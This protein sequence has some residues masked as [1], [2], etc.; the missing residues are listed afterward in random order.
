MNAWNYTS[1]PPYV[2]MVYDLI[3]HKDNFT[4]TFVTLVPLVIPFTSHAVM[5]H[6]ETTS[7][8]LISSKIKSVTVK[9]VHI[10]SISYFTWLYVK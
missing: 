8:I 10:Y 1:T 3:K 9:I 7:F 6:E 2:F 5:Q 4:F